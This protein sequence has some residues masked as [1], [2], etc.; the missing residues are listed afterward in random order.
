GVADLADVGVGHHQDDIT[1]S[2]CRERRDVR[3]EQKRPLRPVA[4][5]PPSGIGPDLGRLARRDA[6]SGLAETSENVPLRKADHRGLRD[7]IDLERLAAAEE[8]GEAKRGDGFSHL[9][10]LSSRSDR[11]PRGWLNRAGLTMRA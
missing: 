4:A 2:A 11:R 9:A 1:A 3:V 10:P 8:E 6:L 7:L 5:H